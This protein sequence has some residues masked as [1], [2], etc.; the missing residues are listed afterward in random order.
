M[1]AQKRF[2]IHTTLVK[3]GD[4]YAGLKMFFAALLFNYSNYFDSLQNF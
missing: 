1:L 2:T 4:L 3:K